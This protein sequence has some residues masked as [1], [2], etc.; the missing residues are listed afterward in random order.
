MPQINIKCVCVSVSVNVYAY[1]FTTQTS[2][3]EPPRGD[4]Q[5]GPPFRMYRRLD[6]NKRETTTQ[7]P[8]APPAWNEG[9]KQMIQSTTVTALIQPTKMSERRPA[10]PKGSQAVLCASLYEGSTNARALKA[11]EYLATVN[12][13]SLDH[14]A[15]NILCQS[16]TPFLKSMSVL[17]E[18]TIYSEISQNITVNRQQRSNTRHE[19]HACGVTSVV[20]EDKI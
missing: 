17:L 18:A 5:M 19:I 4:R 16:P 1:T 9:L 13:K 3:K 2:A 20:P 15:L 8:F 12:E 11:K 10:S 6:T 7:L 14:G